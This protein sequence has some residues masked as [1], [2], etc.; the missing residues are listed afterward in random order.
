MG[1]VVHTEGM[2]FVATTTRVVQREPCVKIMDLDIT[3]KAI[4]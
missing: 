1:V 3:F 2:P 4:V